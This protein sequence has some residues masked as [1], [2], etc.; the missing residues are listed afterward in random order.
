MVRVDPS[1]LRGA[2]PGAEQSGGTHLQAPKGLTPRAPQEA[3]IRAHTGL[4]RDHL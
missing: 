1:G 3:P 4:L 2:W